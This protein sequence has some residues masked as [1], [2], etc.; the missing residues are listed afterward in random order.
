MQA[1]E[2]LLKE[3]ESL[4]PQ[5]ILKVYELVLAVKKQEKKV[6][7]KNNPPGYLRTRAALKNCNGAFSEDVLE[8]RNDRL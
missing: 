2:R 5:H 8:E 6:T 1:K 4:S 3:I 7:A